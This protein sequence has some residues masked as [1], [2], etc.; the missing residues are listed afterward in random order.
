LRG[1]GFS[2]LRESTRRTWEF[3]EIARLV[4]VHIIE[5]RKP[6]PAGHRSADDNW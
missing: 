1:A 5:R 3:L 6:F 4:A 2:S